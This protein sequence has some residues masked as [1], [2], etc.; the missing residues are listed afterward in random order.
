MAVKM[1]LKKRRVIA[2][3]EQ[4]EFEAKVL[5]KKQIKCLSFS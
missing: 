4:I 1:K 2:L 3:L 5:E